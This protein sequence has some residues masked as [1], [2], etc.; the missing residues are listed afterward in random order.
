LVGF[1]EGAVV[2]QALP[3]WSFNRCFFCLP[4]LARS[5]AGSLF[6]ERSSYIYQRFRKKK[7]SN[8]SLIFIDSII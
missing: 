1:D 4:E 2:E 7:K 3:L 8:I 5:K 6:Q